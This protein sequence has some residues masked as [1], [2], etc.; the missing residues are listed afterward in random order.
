MDFIFDLVLL[1]NQMEKAGINEVHYEWGGESFSQEPRKYEYH[2]SLNFEEVDDAYYDKIISDYDEK[3][4]ILT[5]DTEIL[6]ELYDEINW[7]K[8]VKQHELLLLL[9][10]LF[11]KLDNFHVVLY[12]DEECIDEKYV[13]NDKDKFID[14]FCNSLNRFKPRGI[15]MSKEH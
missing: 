3:Y 15:V 4:V 7:N 12:R 10:D 5:L 2:N 14:L 1:R 9:D 6:S 11:D 8:D 13:I